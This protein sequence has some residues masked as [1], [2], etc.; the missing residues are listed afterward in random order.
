MFRIERIPKYA[1]W[2]HPAIGEIYIRAE[3]HRDEFVVHLNNRAPD[4]AADTVVIFFVVAIH[5]HGIA[6]LKIMGQPGRLHVIVLREPH[7]L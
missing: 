7:A 3:L 4:P 2:N 1:I 5:F 6:Y